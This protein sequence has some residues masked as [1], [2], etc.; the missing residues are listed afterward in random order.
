MGNKIQ[1]SH[2]VCSVNTESGDHTKM[3]Q[4]SNT[5]PSSGCHELALPHT[6]ARTSAR[7]HVHTRTHTL[8]LTHLPSEPN[9]RQDSE[10]QQIKRTNSEGETERDR[11][12]MRDEQ[13]EATQRRE[14][15]VMFH[16]VVQVEE[17]AV[18]GGRKTRTVCMG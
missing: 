13:E 6:H 11:R 1:F 16:K 14:A 10:S 3:E 7:T 8:L 9:I 5:S 18:Q 12:D 4:T 15:A 17:L 2:T